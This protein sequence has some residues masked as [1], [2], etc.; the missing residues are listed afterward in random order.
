MLGHFVGEPAWQFSWNIDFSNMLLLCNACFSGNSSSY[1]GS[2][3][4]TCTAT[5]CPQRE[6][7]APQDQLS[8]MSGSQVP[9]TYGVTPR[10][11]RGSAYPSP[12]QQN[13]TTGPNCNNLH[14]W[15]KDDMPGGRKLWCRLV[16]ACLAVSLLGAIFVI[17]GGLF[18]EKSHRMAVED[19]LSLRLVW[20]IIGIGWSHIYMIDFLLVAAI[21]Q[22][23]STVVQLPISVCIKVIYS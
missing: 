6:T 23:Y 16:F 3:D 8:N 20:C 13:S 15:N 18:F 2:G 12:P 17:L 11:T 4:D 7:L 21:I 1:A 19:S 14:G 22:V 9:I 5:S 10:P